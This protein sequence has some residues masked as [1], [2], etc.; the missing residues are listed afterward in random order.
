MRICLRR[1]ER[2]Q[3]AKDLVEG[4]REGMEKA[5]EADQAAGKIEN[6]KKTINEVKKWTG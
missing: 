4:G 1:K 3:C 5:A 6:S 2:R